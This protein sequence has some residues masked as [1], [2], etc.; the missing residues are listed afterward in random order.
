MKFSTRL[1]IPSSTVQQ[2]SMLGKVL[3]ELKVRIQRIF[4]SRSNCH[5]AE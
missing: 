4:Y 2:S 1:G 5:Y 3:P